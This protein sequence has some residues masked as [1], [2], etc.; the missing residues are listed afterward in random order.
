MRTKFD[1]YVFFNLKEEF[2]Y[3]SSHFTVGSSQTV[4]RYQKGHEKA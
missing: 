4:R 1:V 3:C 2:L